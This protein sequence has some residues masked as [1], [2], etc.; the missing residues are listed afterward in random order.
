MLQ[1]NP[2]RKANLVRSICEHSDCSQRRELSLPIADKSWVSVTRKT[3]GKGA[4]SGYETAL[5]TLVWKMAGRDPLQ[6]DEALY[7]IE[8][9][10]LR[11]DN[12][13]IGRLYLVN[14]SHGVVSK[15]KDGSLRGFWHGAVAFP[16]QRRREHLP[17]VIEGQKV[18][19]Q[20]RKGEMYGIPR[21]VAENRVSDLILVIENAL[22]IQWEP[23]ASAKPILDGPVA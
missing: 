5:L 16:P 20:A 23:N 21:K 13:D 7:G 9:A 18:S 11:M 14:H 8:E 15:K 22:G 6:D 19:L 4:G 17:V 1:I 2:K 3:S 12:L 10:F